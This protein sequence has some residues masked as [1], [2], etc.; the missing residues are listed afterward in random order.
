[1]LVQPQGA[2]GVR[3]I[4]VRGMAAYL[5]LV[6]CHGVPAVKRAAVPPRALSGIGG[7]I[8]AKQDGLDQQGQ[9]DTRLK[10]LRLV[11]DQQARGNG[12]DGVAVMAVDMGLGVHNDYR[13]CSH[14]KAVVE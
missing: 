9:A 14:K 2:G 13:S 6:H 11:I 3:G 4:G 12:E 8:V 7:A 10:G 1:M 5:L